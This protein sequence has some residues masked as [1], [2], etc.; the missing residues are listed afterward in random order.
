MAGPSLPTSRAWRL[1]W[2][3]RLTRASTQRRRHCIGSLGGSIKVRPAQNGSQPVC[4]AGHRSRRASLC[5]HAWETAPPVG[6]PGEDSCTTKTISARFVRVIA[7]GT[8]TLMVHLDNDLVSA[9]LSAHESE[10]EN[11]A[12]NTPSGKHRTGLN[13]GL[14]IRPQASTHPESPAVASPLA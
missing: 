7:R 3:I 14:P 11:T 9:G 13:T 10:R 12:R 4:C 8:A 6:T 5:P 2:G 1:H